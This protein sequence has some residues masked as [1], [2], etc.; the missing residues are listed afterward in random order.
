MLDADGDGPVSLPQVQHTIQEAF[1]AR[2]CVG[3]GVWVGSVC[4][5]VCSVG[6][7]RLGWEV[8]LSKV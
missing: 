8:A 5:C 7:L 6:A 2:E 1:A 3:V 4:V